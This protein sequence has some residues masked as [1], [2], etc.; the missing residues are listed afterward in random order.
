MRALV[1]K[2]IKAPLELEDRPQ[3]KPGEGEVVVSVKSAAFNRR[4][5][6]ITQGM[7]PGSQPPVVLGSDASGFVYKIGAGVEESWLN[8]EVILNPGLN[9]G[10]D[11]RVQNSEFSP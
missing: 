2:E 7:Y 3:L 4:D 8:Q 11:Q 1:L 6:W 10:E 9:W 5:C